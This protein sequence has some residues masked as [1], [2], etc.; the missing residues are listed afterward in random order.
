MAINRTPDCCDYHP[1]PTRNDPARAAFEED[2]VTIAIRPDRGVAT[3]LVSRRPPQQDSAPPG[4]G[5]NAEALQ[6]SRAVSIG[7]RLV[8]VAALIFSLTCL[9]ETGLA[10][11]ASARPLAPGPGRLSFKFQ[12]A[13]S[14]AARAG[15]RLWSDGFVRRT[16]T[17]LN[18]RLTL[19]RDLEILVGPGQSGDTVAAGPRPSIAVSYDLAAQLRPALDHFGVYTFQG[20]VVK[21]QGQGGR[22]LV[23]HMLQQ[24]QHGILLHELGHG[25]TLT[26]PIPTTSNDEAIADLFA[27]WA[28]VKVLN[29]PGALLALADY[30]ELI[31]SIIK[32][33]PALA[34]WNRQQGY[35]DL[36]RL[37]HSNPGKYRA[38]ARL[39]P[40]GAAGPGG[41]SFGDFSPGPWSGIENVLQPI[42]LVPLR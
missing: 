34:A 12:A 37:Y 25:Y 9:V 36:F 33:F 15:K 2:Q 11:G 32:T 28:A 24:M 3:P 19:P 40:N 31:A 10:A 14:P 21:P 5:L 35:E 29:D 23:N 38:I 30:R 6:P 27:G 42:A 1:R 17:Q 16:V 8:A 13:H 7:R 22:R 26:W 41:A 18:A 4:F 39:I 20:R